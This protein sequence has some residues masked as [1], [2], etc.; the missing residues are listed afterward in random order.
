MKIEGLAELVADFKEK[1][2]HF[3][4][5]TMRIFWDAA[6]RGAALAAARVE[7]DSGDTAK[8]MSP[9]TYGLPYR[10]RQGVR[11]VWGPTDEAGR[12]L[13]DGTVDMAPH[14]YLTQTLSVIAPS[15]LSQ[16]EKAAA[17]L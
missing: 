5:E 6:D 7:K 15:T 16:L 2:E 1:E 4:G 3:Y 11:S 9:G 14:P 12:F 13:E 17:E 10:T 8:S